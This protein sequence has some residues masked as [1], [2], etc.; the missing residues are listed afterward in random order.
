[1][2]TRQ[3]TFCMTNNIDEEVKQQ[4][5][6]AVNHTTEMEGVMANYTL[7]WDQNLRG[8]KRFVVLAAFH[9]KAVLDKN[10]GLVWEQAPD[11]SERVWAPAI[12]ESVNKNVGGTAG[13]RLPSVVELKSLLDHT[14]PPPFLPD[15]IF[16]GVQPFAYWSATTWS[17]DPTRAW[18]VNFSDGLVSAMGK[19]D[20]PIHFWCVRGGM[21]ADQY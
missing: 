5:V 11:V 8:A 19:N 14:L 16:T 17:N 10:T 2:A 7:R 18:I 15:G 4:A 13:W 21:N 9:N 20:V 1:M 6:G 12:F 3:D